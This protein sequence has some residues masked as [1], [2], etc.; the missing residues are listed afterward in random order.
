MPSP[1]TGDNWNTSPRPSVPITY[2]ASVTRA[3]IYTRIS[4]DPTGKQAGI[5][6]QEKECRELA[7][8]RGWEV[9]KVYT[10]NDISAWSGKIR[11]DFESLL[12]DI[13]AGQY[14][15]VLVWAVDRLYRRLTELERIVNVIGEVPIVGVVSGTIDLSTSDGRMNA[16]VV[17]AVAQGESDRKSDR[18]KLQRKDAKAAGFHVGNKVPWGFVRPAPMMLAPDPELAPVIREI[19]ERYATGQ[20]VHKIAAWL[21]SEHGGNF[22]K[23][24]MTSWLWRSGTAAFARIIVRDDQVPPADQCEPGYARAAWDPVPGCD[25][26][27]WRACLTE[28]QRRTRERSHKTAV[29]QWW[30]S[31]LVF[32]GECGGPCVLSSSKGSVGRVFCSARLNKPGTCSGHGSVYWYYLSNEVGKVLLAHGPELLSAAAPLDEAQ[33]EVARTRMEVEDMDS[34]IAKQRDGLAR[35]LASSITA[36]ST[37]LASVT[38]SVQAEID[39]L[40]DTRKV[41]LER[42]SRAERQLDR[43]ALWAPDDEGMSKG[44]ALLAEA[45]ENLGDGTDASRWNRVVADVIDNVTLHWDKITVKMRTGEVYD[46]ARQVPGRPKKPVA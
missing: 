19:Y 45:L 29:A 41:A 39:T 32:C 31:G 9:V 40:L 15:V 3:A 33:A 27:L 44:Y 6:R 16:R 8:Q 37:V 23:G 46:L 38:D 11:P 22:S 5:A 34:L 14:D 17:G 20:G 36:D 13:A 30:L 12:K 25:D 43:D 24:K 18:I 42:L 7:A 1:S 21:N 10:D 26:V 4:R 2:T 28:R 35:F